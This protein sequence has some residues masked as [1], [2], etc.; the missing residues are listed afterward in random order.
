LCRRCHNGAQQ[1][2]QQQ[3]QQLEKMRTLEELDR[4]GDYI[5]CRKSE[6]VIH[7]AFGE[8]DISTSVIFK[9]RKDGLLSIPVD[10]S[11]EDG[12]RNMRTWAYHNTV[13]FRRG[14]IKLTI[15]LPP[16]ELGDGALGIYTDQE[17]IDSPLDIPVDWQAAKLRFV[18]HHQHT[19]YMTDPA[20]RWTDPAKPISTLN[21]LLTKLKCRLIDTEEGNQI[22]SDLAA[23]K[24]AGKFIVRWDNR[25][26]SDVYNGEPHLFL[27]SCMS[28]HC[29]SWFEIYDDLQDA[30][31]LKMAELTNSAGDHLGRALVWVGQNPNSLYLDRCY[32]PESNNGFDS[33]AIRAFEEFCKN[34]GIVKTV[35][36][37]NKI[38]DL[39][40]RNL[41]ITLPRELEDY[42]YAPYIDSMFC[43]D[44]GK[45]RNYGRGESLQGTDGVNTCNSDRYV[46]T[47]DGSRIDEDEAYWSDRHHEYYNEDDTIL[48]EEHETEVSDDCVELSNYFYTPNRY[49]YKDSD[50]IVE[51]EVGS[52][53]L[54]TDKAECRDGSI[55]HNSEGCT[56]SNGDFV[57]FEDYDDEQAKLDAAAAETK[58]TEETTV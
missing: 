5:T 13:I 1:Q 35:Y 3:Q 39:V 22:L 42:D 40:H 48:T 23:I 18:A 27:R 47:H 53:I 36:E 8:R 45:L 21:K 55:W 44:G 10:V 15:T 31:I 25:Q 54:V 43:H 26:I 7:K 52:V 14:E 33:D 41:T 56:L 20:S 51:T 46:I 4:S 6:Q 2:Q 19:I 17:L 24:E 49:Y 9:L 34:E 29:K 38:P 32:M 12:G 28:G 50:S 58:T 16:V 37:R 57:L 11:A 30:D